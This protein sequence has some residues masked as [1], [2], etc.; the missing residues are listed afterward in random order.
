MGR[1][2]VFAALAV[3]AYLVLLQPA[4]PP[5]VGQSAPATEAVR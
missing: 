1:F 4:G 2:I 5:V 3:A